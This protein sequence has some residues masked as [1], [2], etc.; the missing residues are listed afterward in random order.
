MIQNDLQR[1]RWMILD[2]AL[3][4]PEIEFFMGERTKTNETATMRSLIYYVNQRLKEV[5][6]EFKCS[7]RMLQND[8]AF[9]VQKGAKLEPRFR[10]GHKRILRYIN[11]EWKNPLL[12]A[13]SFLKYDGV[14]AETAMAPMFSALSE[15]PMTA[16]TLRIN[17]DEETIRQKF[18]NPEILQR[19]T[20]SKT[21]TVTIQVEL[22]MSEVLLNTILGMGTSVEVLAPDSLREDLRQA[23]SALQ[24]FYK[25]EASAPKKAVQGDL[26]EGLF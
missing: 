17:K 21:Q 22:P 9:F 8:L 16:V 5:N 24:K 18:G 19:D 3:R 2:E 25:K 15:G 12:K 20:D 1:L 6:R 14:A 7:K 13:A 23:I 4:N 26:F 10:R 11:L